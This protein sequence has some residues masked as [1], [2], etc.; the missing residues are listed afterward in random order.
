MPQI[1]NN[2]TCFEIESEKKI[3]VCTLVMHWFAHR[4][5]PCYGGVCVIV[6][7][8][9]AANDVLERLAVIFPDSNQQMSSLAFNS[10]F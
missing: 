5:C 3:L 9:Q 2:D 1:N 4:L 7:K 8:L 10:R 6:C